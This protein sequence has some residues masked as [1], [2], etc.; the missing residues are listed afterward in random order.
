MIATDETVGTECPNCRKRIPYS[1]IGS[2]PT[3]RRYVCKTCKMS[4]EVT[5]FSYFFR[6]FE[7]ITLATFSTY[8]SYFYGFVQQSLRQKP[9]HLESSLVFLVLIFG[10]LLPFD[11][12]IWRYQIRLKKVT[13][14]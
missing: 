7:V 4:F 13:N 9:G 14:V 8:F 5:R 12:L 1:V 11:Y 2:R 6:I 10:I 3:R